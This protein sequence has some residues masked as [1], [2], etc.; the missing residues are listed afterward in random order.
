MRKKITV[1]ARVRARAG[2]EASLKELL[3]ALIV[4]SRSDE[5]CINYDL[6]QGIDD[7][8][9][10][11]FYENWQSREHLDRHSATPHV[12]LF[13][14]KAKALLAEAPELT[15]LDMISG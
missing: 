14:S 13:R 8:A 7:P 9:L 6:H 1:I 11:I 10:F 4:P 5:G 12:E 3:L 15:L 2:M